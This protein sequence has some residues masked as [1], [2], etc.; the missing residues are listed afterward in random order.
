MPNQTTHMQLYLYESFF[1]FEL[2]IQT[3]TSL[4]ALTVGCKNT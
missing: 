4:N 1:F 3:L 2:I